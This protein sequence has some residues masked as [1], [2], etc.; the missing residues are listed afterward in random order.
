MR[1]GIVGCGMAAR[2]IHVPGL[3]RAGAEVVAFA[4]RTRGSAERVAAECGGGQVYE[5]WG[6]LVERA[7]VDAIAVCTPNR[8]HAP[9]AVAA[10]RRGRHVLVEKPIA[11]TLEEADDMIAAAR[12]AGVVLMPAQNVRFMPPFVAVRDALA[13][14]AVGHVRTFRCAWGHAGPQ[15][16]APDA[17]WF[18]DRARAGGGALLD[19]GVHAVD[20]LRAVLS[21]DPAEVGAMLVP[22]GTTGDGVEEIGEL[23]LRFRGGAVGTVQASWA[24]AHGSDNQLTIQGSAGTV[25]MDNRTPPTLVAGQGSRPEKLAIPPDPPSVF[26]HFVAAVEGRQPPAITGED[27]RTALATVLAAYRAAGTGTVV[28]LERGPA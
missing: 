17:P 24:L 1:V 21:D 14:G 10:A 7:D 13:G 15:E 20:L 12:T 8:S 5:D 18:R 4:S 6:A 27:G 23:I 16:W 3:R 19:L 2:R 11:C 25:H 26:D 28:A 22:R 9:V